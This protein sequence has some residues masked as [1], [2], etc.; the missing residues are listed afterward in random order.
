MDRRVLLST[1]GA[2]E[3]VGREGRLNDTANGNRSQL[4]C[5][6]WTD[7]HRFGPV[8]Y[9][10]RRSSC[11]EFARPV[12]VAASSNAAP[13]QQ[14]AS[15]PE[16]TYAFSIRLQKKRPQPTPHNPSCCSF[17]KSLAFGGAL[18]EKRTEHD[19]VF[20]CACKRRFPVNNAVFVLQT[21]LLQLQSR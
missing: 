12:F 13:R 20:N 5:K 18:T 14:N 11:R 21:A 1:A 9:S 16:Q 6:A 7:C 15:L 4:K 2:W 17:N 19:N 3:R 8:L 10:R